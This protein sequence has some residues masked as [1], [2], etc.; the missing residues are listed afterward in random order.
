MTIHQTIT[1]EKHDAS[2]LD[3]DALFKEGIK[4]I[5][6]YSGDVWTDYNTHDPGITLLEYL[7]FGITDV[8]YRCHFPVTDLLF[9]REGK[10]FNLVD[11]AFFQLDKIMPCAP[12]T[13][14]DYRRLLLDQLPN[15]LDNVW[16]N[17][18][19]NAQKDLKGLYEIV[20]QLN[21][22][23]TTL[24]AQERQTNDLKV[25]EQVR[26][27]FMN[28][29]N[30]CEDIGTINVLQPEKLALKGIIRIGSD[31]SGEQVL[32]DL[33]YQM[34][35]FLAPKPQ[36]YSFSE[37]V[38]AGKTVN[39]ILEGP[40]N[41]HGF[42]NKDELKPVLSV[43][44]TTQI[45][46]VIMA[47]S[48]VQNVDIS[49]K[50]KGVTQPSGEI[51][52]EEKTYFELDENIL[53]HDNYDLVFLR[54]EQ[55][56]LI[57]KAEA[58][59]IHLAYEARE[60]NR[61]GHRSNIQKPTPAS[62][63][64]LAEI[65]YYHSI[66]RLFPN[67]Y[68]IGAYGL[69]RQ[70]DILRQAQAHQLKG[71]LA[72]LETM[73]AGY[74]KQLTQLRDLFSTG[75]PAKFIRPD[76]VAARGI[77]DEPAKPVE[78]T[79][80][81]AQFPFD[82]PDI[83]PL[84]NT[85]EMDWEHDEYPKTEMDLDMKNALLDASFKQKINKRLIEF[86]EINAQSLQRRNQFLDHLLARFGETFNSDL[87]AQISDAPDDDELFLKK[88]IEAK[89]R[90]LQQYDNLSQQRGI[91]F[92]YQKSNHIKYKKGNWRTSNVSWLKKQICIRLNLQDSDDQSLTDYFPFE[93]LE[94][95]QS[96][97]SDTAAAMQVQPLSLHGILRFGDDKNNYELKR[98]QPDG[99]RYEVW[100]RENSKRPAFVLSASNEEAAAAK[101]DVFIKDLESFK[102]KSNNFYVIEHL[103][104]RPKTPKYE[105]LIFSI[106]LKGEN[107]KIEFK[108][109]GKN[110]SNQIKEIARNLLVAAANKGNYEKI[111]VLGLFMLCIGQNK[112]QLVVSKKLYSEAKADELI[113]NL[114]SYMENILQKNPRDV[115]DLIQN[116]EEEIRDE[117]VKNSFYTNRLSIVAPAWAGFGNNQNKRN[118]FQNLV[119]QLAPAHLH[120]DFL[121]MNWAEMKDF[122][123][124]YK[125]WLLAQCHPDQDNLEKTAYQVVGKLIKYKEQQ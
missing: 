31:V 76:E 89:C 95:P 112:Q 82:I 23:T 50:I 41:T 4:W 26:Q 21:A 101:R 53:D 62:E 7:C 98:S 63:K 25:I 120:I 61:F 19:A 90:L 81:F 77:T 73:F 71:Y 111:P 38:A 117:K 108:S 18:I 48:G 78:Q 93:Q 66:Q 84:I 27:I 113:N 33:I 12:L 119:K 72:V 97:T 74:L 28:H 54:N 45:S 44:S 91:G 49:V 22:E 3:F 80:Y 40:S 103:L 13:T 110:T 9:A 102:A 83:L 46:D 37:L 106:P 85:S 99:N 92:N 116:V 69:P 11:N 10:Y 115:D 64:D 105:N 94:P 96:M 114:S 60:S 51:I 34:E 56:I 70:A 79:A 30:L 104:L 47:I 1:K 29:R 55:P 32:A 118:L 8:G 59:Q 17:P 88:L 16:V 36:F 14:T 68:G 6:Q 5:E 67:V 52:P 42:I 87:L 24:D 35:H 124:S 86:T 2:C 20:L 75:V 39:E 100:F 65:A 107:E 57:N 58:T 43:F 123:P 109:L 121:W 122:E 15:E 125:N